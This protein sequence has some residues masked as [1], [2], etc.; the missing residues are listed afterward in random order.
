MKGRRRIASRRAS[1]DLPR[2]GWRV[3]HVRQRCDNPN[4]VTSVEAKLDIALGQIESLRG[5]YLRR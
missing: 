4:M 3:V 2:R 5:P 1:A